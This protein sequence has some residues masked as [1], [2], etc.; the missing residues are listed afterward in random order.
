M[1][2]QVSGRRTSVGDY[3]LLVRVAVVIVIRIQAA[4]V[5]L[6]ILAQVAVD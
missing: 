2:S 3:V 4:G 6:E 1:G 5:I